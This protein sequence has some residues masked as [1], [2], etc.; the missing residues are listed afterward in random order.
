LDVPQCG[1]AWQARLLTPP[2]APAP[3]YVFA[4]PAGGYHEGDA[5]WVR[6]GKVD[7]SPSVTMLSDLLRK[8][9]E[10]SGLSVGQAAWHLGVRVRE[11]REL[12]AGERW[13][14]WTTYDRIAAAF[15]WPRSFA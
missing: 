8:D 13:P 2:L 12:E 5:E 14:D 11:Y 9:R 4:F 7:S 1:D 10:R 6:L 3:R 15:G